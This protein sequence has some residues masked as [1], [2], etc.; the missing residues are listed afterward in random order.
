MTKKADAVQVA[1]GGPNTKDYVTSVGTFPCR[2]LRRGEIKALRAKGV[3]FGNA[4]TCDLDFALKEVAQLLLTEDQVK[5]L[6]CD[7][8]FQSESWG[9]YLEASRLSFMSAA[10]IKNSD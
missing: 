7:E 6:M 5:L 8:I 3:D 2:G 1:Q 9:F 10:Q 4:L